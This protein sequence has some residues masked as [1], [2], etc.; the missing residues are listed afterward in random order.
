MQKDHIKTGVYEQI[1]NQLFKIK[2]DEIDEERFYI[3]RKSIS[4]SDAVH[5]LSKYLQHLIEIAFIGTADEQDTDKYTDFVNSVI[6]TLGKEFNVEDTELDLIDAQK[7]ILTS[8]VDRTCCDYPDFH[9][10]MH[11][12]LCHLK[13]DIQPYLLEHEAA[14]WLGKSELEEVKW[15]PA[16]V[17]VIKALNE[18]KIIIF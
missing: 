11:C 9:L 18:D 7:N 5:I 13:D 4:K 1:I 3:G 17:E 6:K 16:D 8:I 12:Y 15:L 10:T 14:R 2:L